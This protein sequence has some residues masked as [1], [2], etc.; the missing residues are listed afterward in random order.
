MLCATKNQQMGKF[1]ALFSFL[2][3]LLTTKISGQENK[4]ISDKDTYLYERTKIE[5]E[6]VKNGKVEKGMGYFISFDMNVLKK[7][8][9]AIVIEKHFIE[10]TKQAILYIPMET[11]DRTKLEVADIS[12]FLFTEQSNDLAIIQLGKLAN[13]LENRTIYANVIF[14]PEESISDFSFPLDKTKLHELKEH[15]EK[16]ILLQ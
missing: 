8:Y 14:V 6:I 3:L 16:S 5:F 4:K 15:W 11:G 7:L 13:H 9:T 1:A 2:F 12:K 10:N